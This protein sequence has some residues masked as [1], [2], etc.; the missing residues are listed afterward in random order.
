MRLTTYTDYAF[1]CLVYLA[2]HQSADK[3][4][5]IQQIADAFNIS[6]N[7]LTKVIHQLASLGYIE[8]VRG[9]NGGIRLAK[10]AESINLGEVFRQTEPDFTIVECFAPIEEQLFRDTDPTSLENISEVHSQT[11]CQISPQCRLRSILY[12]ATRQFI[13]VMDQYTVADIIQNAEELRALLPIVD[14]PETGKS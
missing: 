6:K 2:I 11:I 12:E 3:L 14:L 5:N 13:D 9:R 10:P 8:S 7:H 1:R 4:F